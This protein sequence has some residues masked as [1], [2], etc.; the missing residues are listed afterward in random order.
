MKH[1]IF[2]FI[3][4]ALFAGGCAHKTGEANPP[5]E[6]A[7]E[8]R[9]TERILYASNESEAVDSGAADDP[10][11]DE[12]LDFLD[13]VEDVGPRTP[14]PLNPLNRAMFHVNDVLYFWVVKP[15]AMVYTGLTP[16]PARTGVRNFFRNLGMPVRMA[17]CIL[18]G[19][20]GRAGEELGRFMVNSTVGFL[21]F[22]DPAADYLD[23]N[24][25]EEDLGQT[26]A[27]YG[28]GDGFYIYWPFF[29]PSTLRDTG[30]MVGDYFLDVLPNAIGMKGN[31]GFFAFK[32]I[33]ST[34][35]RIGEYETLR[36]AALEPYAAL[37]NA[38]IQYRK[39][40]IAE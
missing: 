17:N 21:G 5:G 4:L 7:A 15:V 36:D 32:T 11:L 25:P 22:G 6:I 23:L 37:Q 9:G 20:S 40:K 30:G 10:F 26:L 27:L 16:E 35:L 29:G 3:L 13:E 28:V 12:N 34:A 31:A 19:K 14:D 33:N 38:Y 24:P 2:I 8:L 39:M 18:Q 1:F